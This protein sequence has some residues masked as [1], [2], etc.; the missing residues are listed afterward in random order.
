VSLPRYLLAALPLFIVLGS[1]L[2][3]SRFVL[4]IWL[5]LSLAL[6]MLLTFEFVTW[7]WVA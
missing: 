6:G 4:A 2:A 3:R 7:R 5:A 1:L